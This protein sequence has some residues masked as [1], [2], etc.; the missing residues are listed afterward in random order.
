MYHVKTEMVVVLCR[1]SLE[2][3]GLAPRL[4]SLRL[5]QNKVEDDG[6]CA[7]AAVLTSG[8]NGSLRHL[9]LLAL[10]WAW[11]LRQTNVYRRVQ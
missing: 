9:A 3:R 10:P 5:D 6:A 4:A 2:C 11:P 8:A 7:I 1:K